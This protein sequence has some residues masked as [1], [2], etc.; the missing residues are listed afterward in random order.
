METKAAAQVR[1]GNGVARVI[2]GHGR[3]VLAG[4]LAELRVKVP[5]RCRAFDCAGQPAGLANIRGTQKGL[6]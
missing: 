1:R 3:I 4:E 6:P 2:I 5:Q